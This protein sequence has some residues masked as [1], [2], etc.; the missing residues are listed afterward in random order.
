MCQKCVQICSHFV[1]I[2]SDFKGSELNAYKGPKLEMGQIIDQAWIDHLQHFFVSQ[3]GRLH[4]KYVYRIL[5][6]AE[7]FYRATPD[8]LIDIDLPS[9]ALIN[10]SGDIHGQLYDLIKIFKL[11]GKENLQASIKNERISMSFSL[12]PGRTPFS[13]QLLPLQR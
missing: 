11:Q 4:R 5:S 9:N 8:L 12:S 3:N 1:D 6:L 10:I 2:E 13:Y 7:R